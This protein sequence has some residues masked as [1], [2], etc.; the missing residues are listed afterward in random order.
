MTQIAKTPFERWLETAR[1]FA[2]HAPG[3]VA[4]PNCGSTSLSVKDVEYGLGHDKGVQRYITCGCCGAF[5]GVNVK[6][7]G[8]GHAVHVS[9][10]RRLPAS[11]SQA[12]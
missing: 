12:R 2:R 5:T 1:E 8:E 6:R 3:S 11:P 9:G 4:C 7:A 10:E